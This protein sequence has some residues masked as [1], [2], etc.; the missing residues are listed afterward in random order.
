MPPDDGVTG[1]CDDEDPEGDVAMEDNA[2]V[3]AAESGE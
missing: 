1:A 2:G 3:D